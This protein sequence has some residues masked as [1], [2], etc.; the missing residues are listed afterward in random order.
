MCGH[1]EPGFEDIRFAI[2]S[3]IAFLMPRSTV[4]MKRGLSSKR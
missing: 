2:R 4:T 1:A 3:S